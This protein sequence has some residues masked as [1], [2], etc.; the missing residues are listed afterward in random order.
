MHLL[1]N[2]I[3]EPEEQ[4]TGAATPIPGSTAAALP[5]AVTGNQHSQVNQH[6]D[7]QPSPLLHVEGEEYPRGLMKWNHCPSHDAQSTMM[8]MTLERS[9]L[10]MSPPRE[11]DERKLIETDHK[12]EHNSL[13]IPSELLSVFQFILGIHIFVIKQDRF[14]LKGELW[15]AGSKERTETKS[16]SS[17]LM[18]PSVAT[19]R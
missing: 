1:L 4:I 2:Q 17:T 12:Q 15:F 18:F 13:S 6:S 16:P 7:A 10:Q 14:S 5:K 8:A 11:R 9:F 3:W 19:M